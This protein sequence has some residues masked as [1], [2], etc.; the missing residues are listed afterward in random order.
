MIINDI[1]QLKDIYY[2][3]N[4]LKQLGLRPFFKL[5]LY[6]FKCHIKIDKFSKIIHINIEQKPSIKPFCSRE[7]KVKYRLK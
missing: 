6:C 7:C 3:V 5:E 4:G 1:N 2:S